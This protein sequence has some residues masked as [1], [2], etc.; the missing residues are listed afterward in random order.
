MTTTSTRTHRGMVVPCRQCRSRRRHCARGTTCQRDSRPS[1]TQREREG[2]SLQPLVHWTRLTHRSCIGLSQPSRSINRQTTDLREARG[3]HDHVKQVRLA[4]LLHLVLQ[5]F[6]APR[7]RVFPVRLH[8]ESFS[9]VSASSSK[10]T[11]ALSHT[12]AHQEQTPARTL[13]VYSL[14]LPV[15]FSSS[16][17]ERTRRARR[18]SLCTTSVSIKPKRK[19]ISGADRKHAPAADPS[20]VQSSCE[21]EPH[22][23][24]VARIKSA[25]SY[26]HSPVDA[27][28]TLRSVARRV[29]ADQQHAPW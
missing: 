9:H 16:E 15:S 6:E 14:G 22:A 20:V 12:H 18:R 27:I 3:V 11:R 10:L 28:N 7:L 21:S 24:R 4:R 19:L 2:V 13:L 25:T 17:S 29:R 5:H 26:Y 1:D 8:R 23:W